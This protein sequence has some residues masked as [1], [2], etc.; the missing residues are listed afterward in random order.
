[1]VR[2]AALPRPAGASAHLPGRG[3]RAPGCGLAARG[4]RWTTV[5]PV[6][7]LAWLVYGLLTAL[8]LGLA[9]RFLAR[10]RREE[11]T[12]GDGFDESR[13]TV[14]QAILSGDPTLG[15]N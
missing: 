5:T 15:R 2:R 8:R 6:L 9:L 12:P 10:D 1:D 11:R 7:L 4:W 14:M 3:G 13:V